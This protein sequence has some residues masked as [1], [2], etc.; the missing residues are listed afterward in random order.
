MKHRWGQFRRLVTALAGAPLEVAARLLDAHW[1]LEERTQY[2]QPGTGKTLTAALGKR[3]DSFT[4]APNLRRADGRKS[5]AAAVHD[6]G[7]DWGVWDD[8]SPLT[9]DENNEAFRAILD[10]EEH[11]RWVC[12]LY[13]WGVSLHRM[14]VLWRAKHGHE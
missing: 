8:G 3:Y 10:A 7:W 6:Q 2:V 14:R 13:E 9:F 12:D 4:Y 1:V 5:H 11:P